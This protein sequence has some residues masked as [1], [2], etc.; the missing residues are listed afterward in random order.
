[1]CKKHPEYKAKAAP[2]VLC[3][4]CWG[5]WLLQKWMKKVTKAAEESASE[6]PTKHV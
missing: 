2:K 1:M 4:G 5:Q 3:E 6:R